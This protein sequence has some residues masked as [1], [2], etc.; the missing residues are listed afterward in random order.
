VHIRQCV[1][2][3]IYVNKQ[4]VERR[5]SIIQHPVLN[6]QFRTSS[7]NNE[8]LTDKLICLPII[9]LPD[10]VTILSWMRQ[11]LQMVN[12]NDAYYIEKVLQGNNAAFS[13]LVNR[14]SDMVYSIALKLLNNTSDAEDLSQEVFISA[15]QSLKDYRGSSKFSTWLY[16]ITY[17]KAISKLRKPIHEISTNKERQFKNFEKN[18]INPTVFQDSGIVQE[19]TDEEEKIQ[20]LE[21]VIRQLPVEEQLLIMLH[22]FEEQSVNEISTITKMSVSN[23]KVKLF[24]I[25]KKMKEMIEMID[26]EILLLID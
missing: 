12:L 19:L 22:Y 25:R 21:K 8:H 7:I 20:V 26:K 2:L 1:Y 4:H 5:I 17:N 11:M 18:D 15:Y 3:V 9:I 6:I 24:R 14:Y 10:F 13:Y 23:V 16:R